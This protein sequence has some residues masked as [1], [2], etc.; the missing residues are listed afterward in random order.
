MSRRGAVSKSFCDRWNGRTTTEAAGK[1]LEAMIPTITKSGIP[2]NVELAAKYVGIEQTTEIETSSFDGLLSETKAGM[3]FVTLRKGQSEVRKRFTLAHEVGHAIVYRSIGRQG[4]AT[5]KGQLKCRAETADEKDEERLCDLLATQLLMPREQFMRTMDEA[6]VCAQSVPEIARRFG[7]S[8]EAACRRLIEL[9]PYEIGIGFW[10]MDEGAARVIPK[11]Y[12]TRRGVSQLEHTISVGSPGSR[13]FTNENVR[14]WQWLPLHG[15][16][17]KYFVDVS[18]L[19]T[20]RNS[21][22]MF[23]VFDSAAEHIITTLSKGRS[24]TTVQLP[25]IDD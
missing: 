16:I 5:E 7:V 9:L 15:H 22:L 1:A 24:P 3:Y 6:G 11:W 21:W 10:F 12:F 20:Q 19:E 8:L 17:D 13:C 23:V 14:D 18:P 2:V 25:L 4:T